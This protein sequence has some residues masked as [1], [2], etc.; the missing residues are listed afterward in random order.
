MHSPALGT[1]L[2][3]EA[4]EETKEDDYETTTH[5]SSPWRTT[6]TIID[7]IR[8]GERHGRIMDDTTELLLPQV[9]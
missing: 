4:T 2:N 6:R 5:H 9:G 7:D 8:N 1:L 3:Q